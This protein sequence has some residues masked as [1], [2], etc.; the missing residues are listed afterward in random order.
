MNMD[1]SKGFVVETITGEVYETQWN[2]MT[3]SY[4][5]DLRIQ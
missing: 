5:H 2:E 4:L 3:F 1:Q